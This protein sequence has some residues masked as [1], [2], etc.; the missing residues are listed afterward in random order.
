MTECHRIVAWEVM[1]ALLCIAM[2]L[3]MSIPNALESSRTL[4]HTFCNQELPLS[5]ASTL[6]PA[7]RSGL[8]VIITL[9]V[10]PEHDPIEVQGIHSNRNFVFLWNLSMPLGAINVHSSL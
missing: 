2:K 9:R 4:L 10:S 5:R 6:M 8:G 1:Q 7:S 3:A